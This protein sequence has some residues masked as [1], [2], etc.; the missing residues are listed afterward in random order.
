RVRATGHTVTAAL[1]PGSTG[2]AVLAVPRTSG[3]RCA[4]G[5]AGPRPARAYG[6]LVAVP[7]DG[8][9]DTVHCSFRPP[10]LRL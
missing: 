10:G 5:D 1:P 8:R 4:A 7:L 2:V 3:W 6:G 9:A